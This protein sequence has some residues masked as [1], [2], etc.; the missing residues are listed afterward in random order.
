MSYLVSE[1]SLS[2]RSLELVDAA[3]G[4]ELRILSAPLTESDSELRASI[5]E[6]RSIALERRYAIR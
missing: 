2:I 3:P 6:K 5:L 1:L 4:D